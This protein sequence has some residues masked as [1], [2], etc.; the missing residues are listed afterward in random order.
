MGTSDSGFESLHSDKM[1][2]KAKKSLGQNFIK[3]KG[4]LEYIIKSSNIDNLD[5]IVE[6]GPGLGALTD[7]I[8]K[9]NPKKLLCIEKDKELFEILNNKYIDNIKSNQLLIVNNDILEMNID[10]Y[11]RDSNISEY[12]L[13]ANIPYYITGAIIE[14]FL[15]LNTRP[16]FMLLMLQKEVGERIICKNKKNS[17]LSLA[18]KLYGDSKILKVVHKGSFQ[19]MPKVDSV[20]IKINIHKDLLN[21]YFKLENNGKFLWDFK[22]FEVNYLNIIKCGL[23]HKR[24]KLISNLKDFDKSFDWVSIFEKLKIHINERGEDLPF[25]KWIML[26]EGY[27]YECKD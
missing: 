25:E 6:I 7:Y 17:I 21:K 5:H 4:I 16:S 19:P 13:I 24:K 18:I 9:E 14:K 22:K 20:L 11:L 23:A 2:Y 26:L 3:N 15:N 27:L 12:K 10:N 8:L 1:G